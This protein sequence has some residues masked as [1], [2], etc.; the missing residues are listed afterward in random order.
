MIEYRDIEPLL[1]RHFSGR[2]LE[3]LSDIEVE[4][5]LN[6]YRIN[7]G[8]RQPPKA[9]ENPVL[10]TPA[11]A[12]REGGRQPKHN[13]GL[14][15]AVNELVSRLKQAGI[16]PT[17]K[18]LLDYV[19]ENASPKLGEGLQ[20]DTSHCDDIYVDGNKLVWKDGD[21]TEQW[22]TQRSLDPYV[23]RARDSY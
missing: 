14:Q 6:L 5:L 10:A 9:A 16:L 3:D 12:G 1:K 13:Q 23:K 4:V 2:R 18:T 7:E 15:E 22:I 8:A 17:A 19:R 11:D 21:G 20:L